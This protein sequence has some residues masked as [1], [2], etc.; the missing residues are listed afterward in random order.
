MLLVAQA[1]VP[2]PS[3]EMDEP[4]L[5]GSYSMLSWFVRD[6]PFFAMIDNKK[7]DRLLKERE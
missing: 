6:V 5:D 4:A 2:R 3:K 7:I 1:R